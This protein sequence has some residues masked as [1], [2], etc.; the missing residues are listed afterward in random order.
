MN[1]SPEITRM[2]DTFTG[3][4]DTLAGL[5]WIILQDWYEGLSE[6]ERAKGPNELA[7]SLKPA[8]AMY[9]FHLK[10]KLIFQLADWA[11]NHGCDVPQAKAEQVIPQNVGFR[12]L[13]RLAK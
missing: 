1:K 13:Q 3:Y 11:K 10:G 8:L 6:V 2:I 9:D 4:D 5:L 7:N 12:A